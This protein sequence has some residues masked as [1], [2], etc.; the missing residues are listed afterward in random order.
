[1]HRPLVTRI[2]P[3]AVSLA[4]L[5]AGFAEAAPRI[6]PAWFPEELFTI[7]PDNMTV[8][9]FG[10]ETFKVTTNGPDPDSVEVKGKHIGGSLYPPGPESGWDAW[11]GTDTFKT[12]RGM[13]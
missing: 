8:E 9:E 7:N 13:L 1:M 2:A 6:L 10:S 5:A 3:A 4:L 11:K 12:V